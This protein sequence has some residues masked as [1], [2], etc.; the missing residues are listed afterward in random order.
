MSRSPYSGPVTLAL[1]DNPS[2]ATLSGSLTGTA[3]NGVVTFTGLSLSKLGAGVTLVANGGSLIGSLTPAI[4]VNSVVAT[5]L[6]V[7]SQPPGSVGAGNPFGF[8]VTAEDSTGA[9]ATTFNGTVAASILNNPGSASLGGT[10][11]VTASSGVATFSGLAIN[12]AG[13]GYTLQATSAGL[14]SVATSSITVSAQTTTTLTA[15]PASP[16]Y[17]QAVTLTA[18]VAPTVGSTVAT[19]LVTF[20]DGSTTLGMGS[21]NGSGV[22][23]FTTTSPLAVGSHSLVA[24]YA[25]DSINLPSQSSPLALSVGTEATTASLSVSPTSPAFGQ[26]VTLTATVTAAFGVPTGMVTFTDGSMTLGT[27]MVNGSGVATLTTTSLAVG[28]HPL[29]ATYS[30]DGNDQVSQSSTF[31]LVVGQEATTTTLTVAP[32][33]PVV[34]FP[35]TLTATVTAASG[36][37]TG[38]VTFSDGFNSLGMATLNSSGVAVLTPSI[39]AHRRDAFAD[40]GLHGRHERRHEPVRR[41]ECDGRQANDDRDPGGLAHL[42]RVWPVGHADGDN[43]GHNRRSDR[44]VHLHRRLDDPGD[45]HGQRLGPRHA[46]DDRARGWLAQPG[47]GLWR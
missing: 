11:S 20:T 4:S 13:A 38:I 26:A 32:S 18:I 15:S 28:S 46:D 39:P 34:G 44:H 17:G 31:T 35:I 40:R 1:A 33:S 24:S 23:T 37:P 29:L 47:C 41:H 22:A 45:G 7:T 6:V 42:H 8:S 3:V 30:G 16:A 2:G 21:L 5:Q 10:T 12:Q 25:G 19:G 9:V 14:T 36:S 27:I 43:R